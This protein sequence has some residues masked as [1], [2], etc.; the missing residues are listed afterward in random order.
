MAQSFRC[1]CVLIPAEVVICFDSPVIC[2]QPCLL[3]WRLLRARKWVAPF[4]Q[5]LVSY[6]FGMDF[7][8]GGL[9]H[10]HGKS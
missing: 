9:P 2:W 1:H 5:S 10:P 6:A 7:L 3:K 4:I 8:A